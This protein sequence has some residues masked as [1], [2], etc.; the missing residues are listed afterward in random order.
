MESKS[1]FSTLMEL[2]LFGGVTRDKLFE[3]VGKSKSHFLKYEP[4][5][6]FVTAGEPCTHLKFLL[7]GEVRVTVTNRDGS[8]NFSQTLV[9]PDVIAPDYLFGM[10]T[11]FPCSVVSL[12]Q[13]SVLQISKVDYLSILNSDSVF[14]LNY[15]N[16]LAMNAQKVVEG[17]MTLTNDRVDERVAYWV[18]ALSKTSSRDIVLQAQNREFSQIFGVTRAALTD[19]LERMRKCGLIDYTANKIRVLDRRGLL[20]ILREKDE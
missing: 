18:K 5:E 3:V 9:G 17:V 12:T 20:A 6:E 10:T 2:P 15:L 14:M 19:A 1:I 16:L 8:F 11:D 4:G 7:H 13:A